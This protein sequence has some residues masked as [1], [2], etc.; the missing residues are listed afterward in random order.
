MTAAKPR[1]VP[2]ETPWGPSQS[3]QEFAPGITLYHTAS[4]GG[5]HLSPARVAAMPKA[6]RECPTWAGTNWYEEDLDWSMVVVAFPQFFQPEVIP[7]A[8]TTMQSAH[9]KA[10][11]MFQEAEAGRSPS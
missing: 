3:S 2:V 8:H 7:S 5:F 4:H 9:P 6:L 11:A 10:Y 1:Y